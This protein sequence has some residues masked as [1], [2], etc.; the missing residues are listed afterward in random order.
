MLHFDFIIVQD[1]RQKGNQLLNKDNKTKGK[2][3]TNIL[4]LY[5]SVDG[6][7]HHI[8]QFIA[9][10]LQDKSVNIHLEPLNKFAKHA[11]FSEYDLLIIGASIRYGKHRPYV[12]EFVQQHK[13]ELAKIPTAFFSVNLVARK[14][15]KNTPES[16]M[17]VGK[18]LQLADWQ[19]TVVDV[20][21]GKLDYSLYGFF[22]KIIIKFIMWLT[23]GETRTDTPIVYTDW[24]RVE[25]FVT[26]V[27][28]LVE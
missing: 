10:K 23:K 27:S 13:N 18:F 17:Y 5:S 26:R 8:C 16:N 4:I 19:P 6:H 7:T 25:A 21:A 11:D 3:M 12:T 1:Y 24:E 28:S 9:D 14:A 2:Q 20:F 15:E 22:D